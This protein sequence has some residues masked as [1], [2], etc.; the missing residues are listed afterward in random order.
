[1]KVEDFGYA[2]LVAPNGPP[3]RRVEDICKLIAI[4]HYPRRRYRL[5]N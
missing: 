2:T 1:M 5:P 4:D 3:V